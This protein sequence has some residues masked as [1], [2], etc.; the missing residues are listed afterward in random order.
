MAARKKSKKQAGPD[1]DVQVIL[2]I[3]ASII[4]GVL[5]YTRSGY[6]GETLSPFLGGIIGWVK[7]II[8]I[9]V[10][11]IAIYLATEKARA[12]ITSKLIKYSILIV[13]ISV[14][15]TVYHIIRDNI[16]VTQDFE[17]VV[18]Q[19]YNLGTE[20]IGGGAVRSYNCNTT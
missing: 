7:Y 13:S 20:N 4:L 12:T 1:I 17:Q 3:F 6:I 5:I 16:D 18:V 9:G 2:L 10:L 8:P 14:I 19:A 11:L 15:V